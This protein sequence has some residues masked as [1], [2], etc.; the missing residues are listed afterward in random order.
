MLNGSG[1]KAFVS[2]VGAGTRPADLMAQRA[3]DRFQS[4]HVVVYDRLI[5]PEVLTLIPAGAQRLFVG[6][7]L[8]SG[9]LRLALQLAHG[10]RKNVG[11]RGARTPTVR[12]RE[13]IEQCASVARTLTDS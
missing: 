9:R 4:A 10:Q 5:S 12:F 8:G 1:A 7:A 11:T 13:L 6:K 3:P 2:I